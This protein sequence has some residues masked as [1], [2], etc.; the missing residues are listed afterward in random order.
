M[1]TLIFSLLFLSS[2]VTATAQ[3][4]V[5]E[6]T[7]SD[8]ML[9]KADYFHFRIN[10]IPE[11]DTV[12]DTTGMR[13]DPD[14][15]KKRAE[16]QRQ[17]QADYQLKIENNLKENGFFTEPITLNELTFKNANQYFFTVSTNS[18]KAVQYLLKV[19]SAERGIAFNLLHIGSKEEEEHYKRLFKKVLTKAKEK[20]AFVAGLQNKKVTGILSI[21]DKRLEN[22]YGYTAITLLS[23]STIR[24]DNGAIT[25]EGI[26]NAFPI[27]STI[28]VKFSVQ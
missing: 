21:T 26:L 27:M 11:Y 25:E 13:T 15:M 5:I 20:A 22:Q 12:Y 10:I 1:R 23:G 2:F 28:T 19:S 3:N 6:L 8:T 17:K 18:L 9:I 16:R 24:K 7:V 14:Y 4:N